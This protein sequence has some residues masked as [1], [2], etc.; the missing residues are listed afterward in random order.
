MPPRHNNWPLKIRI[1]CRDTIE[2]SDFICQV[3]RL[4]S[5]S[6][7]P[8][9]ESPRLTRADF[10]RGSGSEP[11]FQLCNSRCYGY[12]FATMKTRDSSKM[13]SFASFTH[14]HPP[15]CDW[16]DRRLHHSLRSRVCPELADGMLWTLTKFHKT[17]QTE[18]NAFYINILQ[19]ERRVEM[20]ISTAHTLPL[21]S[22]LHP[23]QL[24]LRADESPRVPR[25]ARHNLFE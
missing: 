8:A 19:T 22:R 12:R 4:F 25:I 24:R 3:R 1:R 6:H 16:L 10:A 7:T 17:R 13:R 15:N 5:A 11:R 2:I 14:A 20:Q 18:A 23:R 21:R 9:H